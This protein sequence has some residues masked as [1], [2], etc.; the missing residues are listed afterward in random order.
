[1]IHMLHIYDV[2]QSACADMPRNSITLIGCDVSRIRN[3]HI[4]SVTNSPECHSTRVG[5]SN[6]SLRI[7][8]LCAAC[9]TDRFAAGYGTEP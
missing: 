3:V 1:L 6:C 9:P 4:A 2:L 8:H 7:L 5:R